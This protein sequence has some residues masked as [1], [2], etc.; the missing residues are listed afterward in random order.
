MEMEDQEK[1]EDV[2]FTMNDVAKQINY[3]LDF[4]EGIVSLLSVIKLTQGSNEF[5]ERY[6]KGDEDLQN[7]SKITDMMNKALFADKPHFSGLYELPNVAL[8]ND[9]EI[10]LGDTS[11]AFYRE[12]IAEALPLSNIKLI[13]AQ[14]MK[15]AKEAKKA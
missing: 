6:I 7:A 15:A 10:V 11:E 8:H 4:Q 9:F 12:I 5:Y 13:F 2:K 3:L 14:I 1:T